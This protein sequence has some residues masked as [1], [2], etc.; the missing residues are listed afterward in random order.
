M[1]QRLGIGR[2]SRL[3]RDCYA[4]A[5]AAFP[6]LSVDGLWIH[7]PAVAAN[8]TTVIVV[9]VPL[10]VLIACCVMHVIALAVMVMEQHN[11]APSADAHLFG[12]GFAALFASAEARKRLVSR[13]LQPE[14]R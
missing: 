1:V 3:I 11:V 13:P 9:E 5:V 10:L 8:G 4:A 6:V 12:L 14:Q 2:A 7:W